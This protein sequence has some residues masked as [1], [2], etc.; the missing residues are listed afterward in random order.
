M[1]TR[2]ISCIKCL[3]STDFSTK[4]EQYEVPRPKTPIDPALSPAEQ[5]KAILDELTHECTKPGEC[6]MRYQMLTQLMAREVKWQVVIVPPGYAA[7]RNG[8]S[9]AILA[10]SKYSG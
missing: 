8:S 4:Q 10:F 1:A 3:G 5:R 9:N 6:R 7:R 2:I